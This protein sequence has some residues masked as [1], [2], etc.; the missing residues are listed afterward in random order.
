MNFENRCP[1]M[2]TM[3]V[4]DMGNA[5]QMSMGMGCQT[6]PVYECPEERVCHRYICYEVPHIK[7]CNTRIINHHVY[8]HTFTPCYSS[9]EENVV[10]NV[11]DQ[12]CC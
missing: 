11:F 10:E 1:N 12:R 8:R 2:D 4:A 7:P 9:C 3:P 6:M 5:N